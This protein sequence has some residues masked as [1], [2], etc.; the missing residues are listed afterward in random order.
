MTLQQLADQTDAREF[1]QLYHSPT[2]HT[3]EVAD[4]FGVKAT[5][6]GEFARLLGIPTRRQAGVTWTPTLLRV[7]GEKAVGQRGCTDCPMLSRCRDERLW[8]DVLPCETELDWEKGI[9]FERDSF[10]TMG[11]MPMVARVVT[12][13]MG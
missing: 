9:E 5:R 12:E 13:A 8:L 10:P 1:Q 4:R 3:S 7:K 2:V 6:L 11:R